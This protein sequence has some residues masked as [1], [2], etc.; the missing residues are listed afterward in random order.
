MANLPYRDYVKVQ[1]VKQ[2]ST[3][4]LTVMSSEQNENPQITLGLH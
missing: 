3:D 4:V 2:C 1:E